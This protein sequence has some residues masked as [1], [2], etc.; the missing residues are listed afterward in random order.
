MVVRDI[1]VVNIAVA[2][3]AATVAG[4]DRAAFL[5]MAAVLGGVVLLAAR[6]L[7]PVD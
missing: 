6:L 5:L 2:T 3:A 7:Q 1:P 4:R